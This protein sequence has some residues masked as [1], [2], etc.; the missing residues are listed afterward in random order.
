M[1]CCRRDEAHCEYE[2]PGQPLKQVFE[3]RAAVVCS[4]EACGA[5]RVITNAGGTDTALNVRNADVL[6]ELCPR[7]VSVA[8]P[9]GAYVT[10]CACPNE[11]Q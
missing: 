3:E 6:T 11:V 8:F 10:M 1:K 9:W 7:C 4:A 5:P 2:R